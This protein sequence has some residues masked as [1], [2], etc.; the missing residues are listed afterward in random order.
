MKSLTKFLGID[1]GGAHIKIIGLDEKAQISYVGY[2]SC[3]IWKNI[4]NLKKQIK[5]INTISK[6][7]EIK[8]GITM[9][10]ELCDCFKNR[11]K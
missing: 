9:T 1:I 7:K 3:P 6:K 2:N 4:K 10:G 8:C 11:S 5:F